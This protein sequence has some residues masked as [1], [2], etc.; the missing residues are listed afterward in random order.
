MKS[1]EDIIKSQLELIETMVEKGATD[2]EISK[3]IGVGY[4]TFRK[5]KAQDEDIKQI[6]A[7]GKEKKN[8]AVEQAVY[9]CATGYHYYEDVV[10]KLKNEEVTEDGN[11]ITKE[12]VKI[13]SV[14]KYRGPDLAAQK[15]WLNNKEKAKWKDDPNK[16]AI[17]KENL[18]LKKKELE[19]KEW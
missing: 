7:Q 17:D 6:M 1:I 16:V 19:N 4:S 8:Q 9:K 18:K 11:I 13:S 14:K 15:Y 5:Y 3:K 2:K 12:E 10:T